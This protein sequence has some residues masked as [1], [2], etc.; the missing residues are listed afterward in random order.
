[1]PIICGRRFCFDLYSMSPSRYSLT[2]ALTT[3]LV[4]LIRHLP[5]L[6]TVV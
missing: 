6:R 2:L 3:I 5:F 4:M 1:M